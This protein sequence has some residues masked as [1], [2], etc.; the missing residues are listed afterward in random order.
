MK[1]SRG[2]P[3]CKIL[4]KRR[5]CTENLQR[6]EKQQKKRKPRGDNRKLN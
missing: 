5:G 4:L 6:E 3:H 1:Y 2:G